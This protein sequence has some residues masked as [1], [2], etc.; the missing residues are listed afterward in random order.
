MEVEIQDLGFSSTCSSPYISPTCSPKLFGMFSY[1]SAPTSPTSSSLIYNKFNTLS[2]RNNTTP[3]SSFI[4]FQWEEKYGKTN[5]EH[6]DYEFEFNFGQLEKGALKAAE[7]LFEKGKILPLKPPPRLQAMELPAN[8]PSSSSPKSPKS[9]KSGLFR[10]VFSSWAK[11]EF[12]PFEV[13]MEETRKRM[14]RERGRDREPNSNLSSSSRRSARSLSP[15]RVS[16][17]G[18]EEHQQQ[19]HNTKPISSNSKTRIF[20]FKGNNKKWRL[21]DFLLFRSSSE[22]SSGSNR[23]RKAP[24]SAHELHYTANRVVSEGQKKKTF[25]PYKQGLLGLLGFNPT[26]H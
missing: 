12:D 5:M 20:S 21:K 14:D 11:R 18:W 8:K 23:A 10:G 2:I 9:P 3:S 16:N 7:E 19:Q 26:V 1:F 25:L 15:Y 6:E 13:A 22:G 17:L 4:P 24:V